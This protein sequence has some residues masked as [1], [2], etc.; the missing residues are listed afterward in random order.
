[1]PAN[2]TFTSGA[3]L[4]AAQMNNLPWGI[5]DAT[6]GGT[7]GRGYVNKSTNF[8]MTTT[9]ADVT[10]MT[11]TWTA[12]A[13]SLYRSSFNGMGDNVATAQ[14]WI[15]EITNAANTQLVQRQEYMQGSLP[16]S[17]GMERVFTGLTGS[18]TLKVRA[19]TNTANSAIINGS[20]LFTFYVEDIGPSA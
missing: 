6:A 17:I 5:V 20:V 8:T 10:D 4:T 19:R 13:G 7:S 14:F 16:T 18:Q 11:I 12:V 2:T 9:M 3:I 15:I 1:M